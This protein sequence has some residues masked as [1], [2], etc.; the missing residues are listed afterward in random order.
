MN[1]HVHLVRVVTWNVMNMARAT[2]FQ[3]HYLEHFVS[4]LLC[5]VCACG[6]HGGGDVHEGGGGRTTQ[7]VFS[8][9]HQQ[10]EVLEGRTQGTGSVTS[11][12][13]PSLC[14]Y[15]FKAFATTIM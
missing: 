1:V 10:N 6:S 5:R 15:S 12:L 4:V 7:E 8:L 13:P 9:P 2:E 3:S 14:V 11:C